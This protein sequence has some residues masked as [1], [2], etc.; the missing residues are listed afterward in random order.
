MTGAGGGRAFAFRPYL[1]L[2]RLPNLFTAAADSLAGWLIVRGSLESPRTWTLLV[3][4]SVLTYAGGI[5]LNDVFDLDTD[6][7]ER[8][9]RPIPSGRVGVKVAGFVGTVLLF[10]ALAVSSLGRFSWRTTTVEC[11][12]IACVL[13]YNAGI[14]RMPVG[15]WMM[16]VCR[17]LNLLLGMSVVPRFG[18]PASWLAAAA[19]GLFVTGITWISRSEAGVKPSKRPV[20]AGVLLES[21]AILGLLAATLGLARPASQGWA[22]RLSLLPGWV[23]LGAVAVVVNRLGWEA[24]RTPAPERVRRAVRAGIFSLVWLHVGVLLSV[25]GPL[26]AAVVGLLWFPAVYAGRWIAST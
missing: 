14:K 2:V 19:Y 4:V 24:W 6:R 12:L 26:A 23:V 5:V 10:L 1:Q 7:A 20:A 13:G 21:A 17:G 3:A 16:G 11:A 25:R 8:P 9:E 15:P 22:F 18:G